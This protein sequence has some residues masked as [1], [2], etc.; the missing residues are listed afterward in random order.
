MDWK[1]HTIAYV[2]DERSNLMVMTI[3]LKIIVKFEVLSL[4]QSF[5]S[6]CFGHVFLKTC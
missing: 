1:K 6:I 2:K 4:D 5:Q 3:I